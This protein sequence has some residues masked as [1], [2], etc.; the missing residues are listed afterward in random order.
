MVDD[1]S[2]DSTLDIVWT[3]V[4]EVKLVEPKRNDVKFE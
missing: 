2:N 3:V 4:P 1:S